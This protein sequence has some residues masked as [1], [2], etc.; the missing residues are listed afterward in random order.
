MNLPR[1]SRENR[2]VFGGGVSTNRFSIRYIKG[3]FLGLLGTVCNDTDTDITHMVVDF[4]RFLEEPC[5]FLQCRM[6]R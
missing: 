2:R 1:I 3:Y 4:A 5:D 6:L